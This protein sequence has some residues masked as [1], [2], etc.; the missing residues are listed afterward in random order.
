MVAGRRK[1]RMMNPKT[2]VDKETTMSHS[3]GSYWI[4]H[5]KKI[6]TTFRKYS[7]IYQGMVDRHPLAHLPKNFDNRVHA[8]ITAY[9]EVLPMHP[10]GAHAFFNTLMPVL[11]MMAAVHV[12]LRQDEW[13]V[14]Q[15]GR[16][17]YD[18]F[19]HQ[20][21]SIPKLL[22]HV[23]RN[24]MVSPIFPRIMGRGTRAMCKSGRSDTFFIEY[25]FQLQPKPT[26]TMT[27]TQCG[28]VQFMNVVGLDEMY[29]YCNIFDFAQADSFG[30]GL[31]QPSCLGRGDANCIYHFTRNPAD[32]TYPTAVRQIKNTELEN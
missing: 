3:T 12:V 6:H 20:F 21:E 17:S 30:L 22:R 19:F 13:T 10:G 32:T 28:M 5:E 14:D 11:G 24:L 25:I 2:I 31:V 4:R 29:R 9:S 27:C 26:T 15:V 7:P 16:I 23:A 1:H 18:V 8:K